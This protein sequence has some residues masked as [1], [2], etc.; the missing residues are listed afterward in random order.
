[1]VKGPV[2]ICDKHGKVGCPICKREE[3]DA[4]KSGFV[5]ADKKFEV[6]TNLHEEYFTDVDLNNLGPDTIV[7][8]DSLTQLSTSA[9][10]HITKGE[11]DTY[12]LEYDDWGN[13]GK[14]M[15]IFLS[16]IQAGNFNCVV[17]SHEQEVTTEGGKNML[18]PVGGTR[19]F[20][21]NTAKYF[22]HVVYAERKNKKHIFTS[23]T[24]AS[25]TILAGSRSDVALESSD[26]P[27]LLQIFK[28]EL[29]GDVVSSVKVEGTKKVEAQSAQIVGTPA[30]TGNETAAEILAK[31][32]AGKN[33]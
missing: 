33:K 22:G 31:L 12:K 16:H 1:M 21:R 2:S 15:D 18:V 25:T 6:T 7:V 28:P 17:I 30:K 19:N 23:S 3:T 4:A 11:S 32:K 5:A 27:S 29:Y 24:T 20:S 10:A 9:I 13:L 26:E 8:F 14:L